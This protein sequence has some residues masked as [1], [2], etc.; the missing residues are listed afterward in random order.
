M[1]SFLKP[2]PARVDRG[3]TYSIARQSDERQNLSNFI[4][5]EDGRQLLFSRWPDQLEGCPLL[6]Q[7]ALEEELDP[8]Q[9]DRCSWPRVLL[10]IL[11][12]Q[13]ILSKFLLTDEV[14]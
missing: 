4:Y 12:V 1:G 7:G 6:A 3:Q 2:Q 10:D 14:G 11:D 5:A 9:G 8:A 13:E